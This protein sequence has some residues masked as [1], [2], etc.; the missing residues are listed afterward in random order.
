MKLLYLDSSALVKLVLPEPETG[1]LTALLGEWPE[2]VSSVLA[3]VEVLRA[4]GR[5]AAGERVLRRA[6]VVVSRVGLVR[7]DEEV[8]KTASRLE[9]PE[10]RSLDAIHLATAL[11]IGGDLGGMV[12]Y[13][14]RLAAVAESSGIT[15]FSPGAEG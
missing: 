9:S 13:D 2:L 14:S 7:I 10:L 3:R 15:T 8:L 5:A 1:A 6:E 4:A 11:S 12:A